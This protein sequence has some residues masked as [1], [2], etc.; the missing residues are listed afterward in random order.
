MP[1]NIVE[2][3]FPE[4]KDPLSEGFIEAFKRAS[5]YPLRIP[6]RK[7]F[8]TIMAAEGDSSIVLTPEL[9]DFRNHLLSDLHVSS[10]TEGQILD[11]ERDQIE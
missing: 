2:G 10:E 5:Q 6:Y 7:A 1:E 9:Q 11:F 8:E 4:P 3:K